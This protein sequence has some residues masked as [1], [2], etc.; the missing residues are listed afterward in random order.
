MA[1]FSIVAILMSLGALAFVVI[2][3]LR[4]GPQN[5]AISDDGSNVAI[6]KSQRRELDEELAR[7]A[8]SEAEHSAALGELSARVVDEVPVQQDSVRLEAPTAKRP[9]WLVAAIAVLL[10][11]S[12]A[13]LYKSIGAPKAIDMAGIPPTA[14]GAP[15]DHGAAAQAGEPP[16]S[17]KQILAMVDSLALKMQQ[18]PN[19]PRGWIL[20]ARSQNA[21]GRFTE[22][23]AAFERAVALTP[24]DAQLLADFADSSVMAQQGRFEGKPVALIKQALTIDPNNMK[25]L[26]LAGTAEL[27]MGNRPESLKHWEKLKTLVPKDSADYRE[28]E[29]IIA[30]VKSGTGDGAP[31][32][33]TAAAAPQMPPA[34]MPQAPVNAAAAPSPAKPGVKVTGKVALAPELAA[35]LAPGDTLFVFARAKEGPRMPLAVLRVPAPKPGAFP[36]TFELNDAMAMAPGFS[37]SAFPEVVIEA[38]ISKSGNAQMQSGDLSGITDVV[39]PGATGILVTIGKVAP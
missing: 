5:Q 24:Q 23:A 4:K 31:G 25:A 15:A 18:N 17:D 7:G 32:P 26:A 22:A 14:T 34:A 36:F 29:S 27:R 16:M 28:V 33:V 19:D 39:K 1:I 12:A 6:Y 38:R 37:L 3:L 10:P 21:L 9:W 20:L 2:P 30:E 35:K 11:L 13:L 8:I